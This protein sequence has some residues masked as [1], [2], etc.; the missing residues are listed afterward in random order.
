MT[1]VVP[2]MLSSVEGHALAFTSVHWH[3]Q[4]YF[5]VRRH[6]NFWKMGEPVEWPHLTDGPNSKHLAIGNRVAC[7]PLCDQ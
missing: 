6:V 4:M 2:K 5:V 7:V 1:D 3:R